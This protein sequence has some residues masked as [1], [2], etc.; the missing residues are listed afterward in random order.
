MTRT[1]ERGVEDPELRPEVLAAVRRTVRS[2]LEE[3]PEY[4]RAPPELR[5]GLASNMVKVSKRAAELVAE[6]MRLTE[7]LRRRRQPV[8]R[9][10]S[11]GDQLGLQA[12]RSS[13]ATV[14]ELKDAID[15]PNFVTS[16]ISGVFQAITHSTLSQLESL[17]DL[18]DNVGKSTEEFTDAN[19][20]DAAAIAWALSKFG[21]L[22]SDANGLSLREGAD[23]EQQAGPLK[24]A[25]G[26]SDDE[27]SGIDPGDL[28]GTLL[29]LA[30]RKM[31]KSRQSNL[32]TMVQLGLQRI[33]VD[34]GRLHASME[35]RVDTSS[36]SEE[37]KAQRDDMRVNAGASGSFGIGP[38]GASAKVDTSIGKVSSDTQYTKEQLESRAALRSSVDLAFR[39]D[40]IPLDRM[41]DKDAR[42]KL[43]LAAR[44]PAD[45]GTG[46]I[47]ST[48]PQLT[49]PD[50]AAVMSGLSPSR[51][52]GASSVSLVM[53]PA[54]RSPSRS[55]ADSIDIG[56]RVLQ[57]PRGHCPGGGCQSST[58][59]PS[60]S[61]TQPNFPYSESSVFSRTSQPSCRSV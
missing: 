38:W 21:F 16:L 35:L 50:F 30:K 34:E 25:L 43:N 55:A 27:I 3:N 36:V 54:S 39:T 15:F 32:A 44:V 2:L 5:Q 31:G 46:L 40:Q 61:M 29:P 45:V 9:A 20:D 4:Q 17:G 1:G 10:Q 19:I 48:T 18:L 56:V 11:A 37:M 60:G 28:A 42:V 14:K 26:A 53:R 51:L 24:S 8:A 59:L 22:S 57:R 49:A 58:L 7:Q 33:V 23:L 47:S 52:Y 12:A 6:E 13:G 41:A